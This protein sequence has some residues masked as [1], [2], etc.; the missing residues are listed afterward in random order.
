MTD[1][2]KHVDVR[3]TVQS[4]YSRIRA[5]EYWAQRGTPRSDEYGPIGYIQPVDGATQY[6]MSCYLE[7][8]G[9]TNQ[10]DLMAIGSFD[11]KGRFLRHETYMEP[12]AIGDTTGG[13]GGV[14]RSRTFTTHADASY[15]KIYKGNYSDGFVRAYAFQLRASA[16]AGTYS[17]T[18]ATSGSRRYTFDT[19]V[20]GIPSPSQL[21]FLGEIDEYLAGGGTYTDDQDKDGGVNIP[22]TPVMNVTFLY[23]AT[24]D[25]PDGTPTWSGWS[26][27]A[28]TAALGLR[29]WQIEVFLTGTSTESPTV[30]MV[31]LE[32]IRTRAIMLTSDGK[33]FDLPIQVT[34]FPVPTNDRKRDLF[35][36]DSNQ[37]RTALRGSD[38][39]SA[40]GFSLETYS[41]QNVRE[42]GLALNRGDGMVVVADPYSN[43]RYKLWFEEAPSWAIDR[44]IQVPGATYWIHKA[45][46]LSAV[47]L[48]QDALTGESIFT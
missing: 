33:E 1:A 29:Y 43:R 10:T 4:N 13:T 23:R 15:V 30:D 11:S 5:V 16:S 25:D 20:A 37:P 2:D 42:F 44:E 26:T 45:E 8:R 21:D 18:N 22:G 28:A 41:D 3:S 39:Y 46:G 36:S 34:E 7:Y 24:D 9:I 40:E 27:F 12:S 6:T 35:I 19:G 32:V 38:L 17:N 47:V 48:E 31:G 14:R